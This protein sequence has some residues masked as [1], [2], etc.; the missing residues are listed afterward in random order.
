M[1]LLFFS[2]YLYA[3][4]LVAIWAYGDWP[5]IDDG[6]GQFLL[7]MCLTLL[8]PITLP[9]AVLI[10]FMINLATGYHKWF[11]KIN[12]KINQVNNFDNWRS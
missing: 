12:G 6:L 2:I 4:T 8:F 5:D 10:S 9:I 11:K 1:I 3:C 7:E